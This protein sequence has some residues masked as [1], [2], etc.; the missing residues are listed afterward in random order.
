MSRFS[1][2]SFTRTSTRHS[3]SRKR[4]AV[5][6]AVSCFLLATTTAILSQASHPGPGV[7][8]SV[9][10]IRQILAKDSLYERTTTTQRQDYKSL[11]ERKYQ[12]TETD[13]CKMVIVVSGHSHAEMPAQNR[14]NDRKWNDIYH[15]D[16]SVMDPSTVVVNEPEPPQ[17]QWQ[18]KGY[19]V[20]ISVEIGK[21]LMVSST[22]DL[23]T[24]AS[25]ILPGL[26]NL[27]VYVSSREAADKLA[28]TFGQLATA[29]QANPAPR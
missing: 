7:Q 22:V 13:G 8:Q 2:L 5:S 4:L 11:T 15:P 1:L 19:L 18:V 16:F 14:I 23:A 12:V 27:A 24:N 28:K 25:R 17:P 21:P 6:A 20:R 9:D 26:P 29:C 3:S 10:A